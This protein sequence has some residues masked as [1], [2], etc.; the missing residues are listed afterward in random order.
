MKIVSFE[1]HR[2]RNL[3]SA[4]MTKSKKRQLSKLRSEKSP[5]N[6][7]FRNSIENLTKSLKNYV[8]LRKM[9]YMTVCMARRKSCK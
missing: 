6:I 9:I 4:K 1:R 5:I 2:S 8:T 7:F 3:S